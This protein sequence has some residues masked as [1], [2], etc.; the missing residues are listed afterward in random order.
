MFNFDFDRSKIKI[1][2]FDLDGT[3]TQH[4]TKLDEK[5]AAFLKKLSAKYKLLMAGAGTCRRIFEQMNRFPVDIIGNYGLQC[6]EYNDAI[7]DIEIKKEIVLGCDR[8]SV[9]ARADAFRKANGFTEYRGNSVEFHPSGC[10][11]IALLG[12]D[13]EIEDKLAFDPD[14]SKRQQLFPQAASL[15]PDYN[16][17]IGGSSSFDMV[18]EPHNKYKALDDYC[19]THSIAH[20]NVLYAGD[21]YM[22]G[23]NDHDVFISDI[24]FVCI[25][26]Y[27]KLADTLGFM[28]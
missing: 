28:L 15:F 19:T 3:L 14:H 2:A 1:I 23:G 7:K 27:T 5:N 11:T 17:F 24:P 26:D 9:S 4:K 12:T 10:V 25:D 20:G 22:P 13:A 21:D 16:V 18:P 8:A 6:A